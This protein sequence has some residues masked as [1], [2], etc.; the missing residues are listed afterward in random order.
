LRSIDIGFHITYACLCDL[1]IAITAITASDG[2]YTRFDID[3]K[4]ELS[5]ITGLKVGLSLYN[6]PLNDTVRR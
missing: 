1:D 3:W 2:N 4:N 6:N 5:E